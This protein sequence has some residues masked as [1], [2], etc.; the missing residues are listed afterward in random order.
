MTRN[1]TITTIRAALKRRSGK[2]W[3]VTGGT[4]TAYGWITIDAPPKRRTW[5]YRLKPGTL[6]LPENYEGYDT[7][8]PNR[9]MTPAD[10][11]ELSKLLNVK[12]CHNQGEKIPASI[13]YYLEYIDRAEGRIPTKT[14]TPYW[15]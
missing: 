8:Q 12:L 5:G 9:V 10:Q 6:D 14:G 1:E 4:G 3:S 7:G 11:A 2:T 15:D 13:D